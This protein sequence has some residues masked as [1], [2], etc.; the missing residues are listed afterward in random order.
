MISDLFPARSDDPIP[1]F[2]KRVLNSGEFWTACGSGVDNAAF[3][4]KVVRFASLFLRVPR[5]NFQLCDMFILASAFLT[6]INESW[7]ARQR[8][9][10]RVFLRDAALESRMK[11][12][13]CIGK[14]VEKIGNVLRAFV[15]ELPYF[16]R[17]LRGRL[18]TRTLLT[19]MQDVYDN[20]ESLISGM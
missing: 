2:V 17:Q 14:E 15:K 13:K 1:T 6:Y 16:Q 18:T 11:D 20:E 19:Y 5:A 8:M 7:V 10:V 12:E 9:S 4:P 3:I